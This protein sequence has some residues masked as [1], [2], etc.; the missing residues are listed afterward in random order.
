M[1]LWIQIYYPHDL[2]D[3]HVTAKYSFLIFLN[4]PFIILS[5]MFLYLL[6]SKTSFLINNKSPYTFLLFNLIL[7]ISFVLLKLD[8]LVI[9]YIF[10]ESLSF[11]FL[12]L[13]IFNKTDKYHI[14]SG[15]KYFL[16]SIIAA[17][18]FIWGV[19]IFYF[20]TGFYTF[21]DCLIFYKIHG[22]TNQEDL[23]FTAIS[24]A[25]FLKIGLFPFH[26]WIVDVYNGVNLHITC[27]LLTLP[28]LIYFLLYVKFYFY[29][30]FLTDSYLYK[31]FFFIA[32]INFI[33]GCIGSIKEPVFKKFIIYSSFVHSGLLINGFILIN[34]FALFFYLLFY[35]FVLFAVFNLILNCLKA[36]KEHK[37]ESINFLMEL[38]AIKEK[39]LIFKWTINFSFFALSGI[40]P[41]IGF[42]FKV[43]LFIGIFDWSFV[44]TFIFLLFANIP[45][46]YYLRVIFFATAYN[47]KDKTFFLPIPKRVIILQS[48]LYLCMILSVGY[49]TIFI[50]IPT[51]IIF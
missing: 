4:A 51:E 17:I 34:F 43:I 19:S 45:F 42:F 8:N 44:F 11:C 50:I 15:I 22:F 18:F 35:L 9:F 10:L 37:Y 26:V 25:F 3:L 41:L 48:I 12:F 16:V 20:N 29:F 40:P 31:L 5:F 28:K 47:I 33:I 13:I 24:L 1:Q 36:D 7:F 14:E 30:N 46:F 32:S 6:I 49:M 27:F 39:S 38:Q 21:S 23:A 2:E